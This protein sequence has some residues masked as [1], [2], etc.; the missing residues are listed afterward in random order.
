MPIASEDTDD[1]FTEDEFQVTGSQSQ[2]RMFKLSSS[3]RQTISLSM[4]QSNWKTLQLLNSCIY[5]YYYFI[6]FF[7][8]VFGE[9]FHLSWISCKHFFFKGLLIFS[10]VNSFV[11]FIRS[12]CFSISSYSSAIH[13][14]CRIFFLAP[15]HV[16]GMKGRLPFCVI[17]QLC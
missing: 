4:L 8:F 1:L 10:R 14:F 17:R 15:V 13:P 9:Q 16:L 11:E 7:I 3:Q 12:P 6:L 2:F 5:Y